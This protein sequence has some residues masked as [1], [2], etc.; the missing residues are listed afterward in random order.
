[1]WVAYRIST[2]SCPVARWLETPKDVYVGN[3]GVINIGKVIENIAVD[4]FAQVHREK[5]QH[6]DEP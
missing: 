5:K 2:G 6:K 1:M 4:E 3:L